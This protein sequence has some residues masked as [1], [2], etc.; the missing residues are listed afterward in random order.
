MTRNKLEG[1]DL[2]CPECGTRYKT[3]FKETV[4]YLRFIP[5]HFEVTEEITYIYSYPTYGA[6]KR[7]RKSPHY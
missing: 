6:M 3:A 5:A 4:K 7:P 2:V 1:E